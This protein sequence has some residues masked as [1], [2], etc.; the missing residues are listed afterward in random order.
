MQTHRRGSGAASPPSAEP[1]VATNAEVAG[2]CGADPAVGLPSSP[3]TADVE[4]EHRLQT[5]DA[6]VE[7]LEKELEGLQD[8]L[9]R[10]EVLQD[11]NNG[12]LR[13]R[14]EQIAR[15]VSRDARRRLL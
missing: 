13:K 2:E 6:R 9:Y 10:H 15:D 3:G 1:S 5:L 12:E 7:R 4:S 14:T 11:R 8:A